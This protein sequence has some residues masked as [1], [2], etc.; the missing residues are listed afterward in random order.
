MMMKKLIRNESE[1]SERI[2]EISSALAET[3][4]K[5]V[6][7]YTNGN[8][9]EAIRKA[10]REA[11][12][13]KTVRYTKLVKT[14]VSL[15]GVTIVAGIV[16]WAVNLDR[17]V[18]AMNTSMKIKQQQAE[19]FQR[20]T[21]TYIE[22]NER[23]LDVIREGLSKQESSTDLINLKFDT[24]MKAVDRITRVVED[25]NRV[26]RSIECFQRGVQNVHKERV[27]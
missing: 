8:T 17:T 15:F 4:N 9:K 24:A 2:E 10:L 25:T 7:A 27:K 21:K 18:A 23:S 6:G 16:S 13:F 20:D 3:I 26:M 11:G 1:D 14:V 5:D 22:L 19:V 12:L